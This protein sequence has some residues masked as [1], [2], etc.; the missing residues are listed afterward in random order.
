MVRVHQF[1]VET[2]YTPCKCGKCIGLH[3]DGV[4]VVKTT[5][6]GWGTSSV[7]LGSI[8][9]SDLGGCPNSL[10]HK[11]AEIIRKAVEAALARARES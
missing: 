11:V 5:G 8:E 7:V 3:A 2:T 9:R 1:M 4:R 6:E 10:E